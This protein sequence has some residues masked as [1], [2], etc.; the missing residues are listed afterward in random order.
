M[1]VFLEERKHY[2]VNMQNGCFSDSVDKKF[3]L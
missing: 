3:K 1:R 2:M